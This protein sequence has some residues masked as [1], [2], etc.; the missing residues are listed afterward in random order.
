M[1]H[2]Q[3]TAL[4]SNNVSV[5]NYSTQPTQGHMG[6]HHHRNDWNTWVQQRREARATAACIN[7]ACYC[8]DRGSFFCEQA[9]NARGCEAAGDYTSGTLCCAL[10]ITTF[11]GMMACAVLKCAATICSNESRNNN[12]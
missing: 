2:D 3:T 5:N 11:A 1:P 10:G 8:L 6:Y 7:D 12:P 4:I 9:E